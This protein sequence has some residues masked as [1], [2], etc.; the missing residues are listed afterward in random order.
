MPAVEGNE[1]DSGGISSKE[2]GED[3]SS[4]MFKIY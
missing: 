2:V 4:D 3:D 1:L